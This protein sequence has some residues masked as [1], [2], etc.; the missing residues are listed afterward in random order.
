MA[1]GKRSG[2]RTDRAAKEEQRHE[3]AVEAAARLGAQEVDGATSECLVGGDAESTPMA[4]SVSINS[5]ARR[6]SN[7]APQAHSAREAMI[8]RF[9]ERT[10]WLEKTITK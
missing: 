10:M 6:E 7:R 8:N 1:P 4:P 2:R 9:S 3:Q 5:A